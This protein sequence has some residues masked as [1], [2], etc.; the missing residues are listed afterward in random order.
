MVEHP[1]AG[2]A[3]P[4]RA[5]VRPF[6]TLADGT[7]ALL[8]TLRADGIVVR[9]CDYGATLVALEVPDRDGTWG[10]VVLGFADVTGY[11][12]R[13]NNP[14]MGATVGRVANRIAGARFVLDGVEHV[15]QANEGTNHLHGGRQSSFDRVRWEVVAAGPD[16]VRLRHVS[17]DGD[18][19]YPG[20]L[21]VEAEYRVTPSELRIEYLAT[22]DRRTPVNMTQHAYFNLA[23]EQGGTVLDHRLRVAADAWTPVDAALIPT[24]EVADVTGTPFDLRVP[25]RLGDGIAALAAGGHGD[26]YD[27]SL[28]LAGA[29][30]TVR[31]VAELQDRASGRRMVLASDQPCLQVYSGN[32]LGRAVGRG[33]VV[34]PVHGALCLEPQHAP[35]SVHRPEWPTIVLEP[36]SAYEHRIAYRFDIA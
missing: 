20:T 19:G 27:H 16:R 36:G 35:D 9:V 30:G 1:D 28:W 6:G 5:D 8:H 12:T 10:G 32:R 11:E 15:L 34:F 13:T 4:G 23:G 26:G 14:F 3:A 33:G 18:A 22:T 21:T 7:V 24:G 17:P 29:A 2:A 25:L 31:D